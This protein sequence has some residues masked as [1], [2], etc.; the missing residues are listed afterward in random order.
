MPKLVAGL[1]LAMVVVVF[2]AQNTQA[3]TFH[4][5][6][7]KVPAV[8]LV[9]PLFGAVLLGVLLCLIVATPAQFRRMRERRGLKSTVAANATAQTN[10]GVQ[11]TPLQWTEGD[12]FAILL[13]GAS[14][15]G[16]SRAGS[17]LL[18]VVRADVMVE[19]HPISL[20]CSIGAALFPDH[21]Q[22]VDALMQH[23]D[24]AMYVAKRDGLGF[25]LYDPVRDAA[26]L[27]G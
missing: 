9:L 13:P 12:E 14:K 26:R 20:G 22:T 27:D 16:A 7:F 18:D 5:L 24:A 1:L 8:P 11:S 4:F 17:K 3:I 15:D 2:G 19:N 10:D 25:I 21:A 23:A 6:W